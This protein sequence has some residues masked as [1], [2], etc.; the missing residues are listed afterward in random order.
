M[1]APA[2][3]PAGPGDMPALHRA[4]CR[5]SDDLGD[6]HR[7]DVA[8]LDRACAGPAP[9]AYGFLA[10]PGPEGAA[11]ASPLFSTTRGVAGVYVSDLWVADGRRG[12]GLG[13]RLLAHV[14]R[15]GAGRWGAG[16]LKLSVYAEN[17]DAL[18]FYDRLGFDRA[19]RDRTLLL[20]GDAFDT[21]MRDP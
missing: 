19:D 3:R 2:I 14:A 12:T 11:L 15:F 9:A 18:A 7:A 17:A 16:F 8:A 10:G 1:D 21:L 20:G 4:L 5:L 6:A 13:R